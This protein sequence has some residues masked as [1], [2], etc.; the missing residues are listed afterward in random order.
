M[1]EL[2]AWREGARLTLQV[3]DRGPGVPDW[4]ASK[5]W[6]RFWSTPRPDGGTK[7]SG[8]GL[9]FVR[10]VARLHGGTAD[11]RPRSGGGQDMRISLPA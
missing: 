3:Q 11:G 8:L 9:P 2:R 4:A 1:V 5:I 7:S 10:E 6:E